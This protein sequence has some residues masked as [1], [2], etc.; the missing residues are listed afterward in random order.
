[1]YACHRYPCIYCGPPTRYDFNRVEEDDED[2][3]YNIM[4]NLKAAVAN[5]CIAFPPALMILLQPLLSICSCTYHDGILRQSSG[6]P[7]RQHRQLPAPLRSF[8]HLPG[9]GRH[10]LH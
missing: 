2:Q 5:K 8:M 1:M 9:C 3:A 4:D 10:L 6:L 7:Q